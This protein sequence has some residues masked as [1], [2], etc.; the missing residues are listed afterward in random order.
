MNGNLTP[1]SVCQTLLYDVHKEEFAKQDLLATVNE[2]FKSM[3][4]NNP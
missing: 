1:K 4:V 2:C 3:H